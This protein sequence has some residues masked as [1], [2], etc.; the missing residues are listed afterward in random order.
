[1]IYRIRW[2][3]F[4]S[5]F[6]ASFAGAAALAGAAAF[7]GAAALAGAAWNHSRCGGGSG[8]SITGAQGS[9]YR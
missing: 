4:L 3:V 6:P 5:T 8:F 9:G 1:M 2:C 7:P